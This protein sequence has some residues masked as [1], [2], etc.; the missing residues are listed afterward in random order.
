MMR[1]EFLLFADY[2]QFYIQDEAADGNLSEAWTPDAV[3]R[4]LALAPGVVGIGTVRNTDVP[5]MI[6]V[7]DD[8]PGSE[9][10]VSDQVVECSISIPSGVIVVAGCTDY[11]PDAARVQ[12]KPG[13]YR[14]RAN[15]SGLNSVSEDGATGNGRYHLQVWRAPIADITVHKKK[16]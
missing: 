12:V 9:F 11:F 14:V 8:E 7:L 1:Y 10:G 15:L 13:S 2:H 5:V 3:E 6:D 4:L 16:A